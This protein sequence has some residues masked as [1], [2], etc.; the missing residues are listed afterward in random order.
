MTRS[1]QRVAKVGTYLTTVAG[2]YLHSVA[3]GDWDA[4]EVCALPVDGYRRCMTCETHRG[5]GLPLADRV[6]L[7]VYADKPASQAYKVMQGYKEDRARSSFRPI[8]R[9]LLAVGLRG[10]FACANKLAGTSESGWAVVPSSRGRT[11][12]AE[13]VRGLARRPKTEVVVLFTGMATDRGL[14]PESWKIPADTM[15]PNHMVVIEDA[16]VT[17]SSAQSLAI[18]LK[19]A[20]AEQVSILA[21]ARVLSPEW[22][23]NRPFLRVLGSLPYKWMI[24]PWTRGDCR[25]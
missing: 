20:G 18:A 10:H 23:A 21:V 5:S 6:G 13:L 7:L 14:S 22:P 11:V 4:C 9:A 24:C 12:L 2:S 25:E 17:G 15:V 3:S 16:W 8:V 19:Q 1:S